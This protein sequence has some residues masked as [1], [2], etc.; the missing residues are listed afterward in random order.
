MHL[1]LSA[2]LGSAVGLSLGLLGGGGSILTVPLLRY[3]LRFSE[4]QAI[5]TSLPIVGGTSLMG[6]WFHYRH[7]NVRVLMG[8]LFG[9]VGVAAAIAGSH[10]SLRLPGP[11]LF[12]LFAL[13]MLTAAVAMWRG[14]GQLESAKPER[15]SLLKVVLSGVGVG[16]LTGF[17]GVGGGF[18]IV[19]ALALFAGLPMQEAVGTSLLAIAIN[20]GAGFV[21]RWGRVPVNWTVTALFLVGAAGGS[22]VGERIARRL[23]AERL[24]RWFAVFVALVGLY[25]LVENLRS[26]GQ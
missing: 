24:R 11:V 21:G 22:F 5:T 3:L 18:L 8:V 19:P 17:L 12:I 20:C 4:Q 10:L 15:T 7:G 23:S 13:I 2:V 14:K 16:F 25:L 26:I 1:F 9:G 6:A